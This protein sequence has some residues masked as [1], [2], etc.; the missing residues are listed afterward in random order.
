MVEGVRLD[1]VIRLVEK[2]LKKALS[3]PFSMFTDQSYVELD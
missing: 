1:E 2:K 3:Q